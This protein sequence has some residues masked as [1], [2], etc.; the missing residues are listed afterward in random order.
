MKR[1]LLILISTLVLLVSG[2]K[3]EGA[4]APIPLKEDLYSPAVELL[5][6]NTNISE[7]LCQSNRF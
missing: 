7:T 3:K 1:F 5:S 2:C 4:P 6:K